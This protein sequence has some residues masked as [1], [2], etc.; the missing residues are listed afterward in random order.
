MGQQIPQGF[1]RFGTSSGAESAGRQKEIVARAG[2]QSGGDPPPGDRVHLGMGSLGQRVENVML[3]RSVI[4]FEVPS[5]E[6]RRIRPPGDEIARGSAAK[7]LGSLVEEAL[8][9]VLW[10]A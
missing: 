5:R 2:F 1:H 4:A 10:I 9:K 6:G 8:D 3:Q 7:L